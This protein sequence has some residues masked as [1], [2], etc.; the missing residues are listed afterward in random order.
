MSQHTVPA[1]APPE[2]RALGMQPKTLLHT[3]EALGAY[4]ANLEKES[5]A[6]CDSSLKT[7]LSTEL[8]AR[9]R[10]IEDRAPDDVSLAQIGEDLIDIL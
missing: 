1:H 10:Q 3:L 9:S 5:S 4:L 8:L 7:G 2:P 6:A